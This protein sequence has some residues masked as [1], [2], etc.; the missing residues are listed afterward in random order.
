MKDSI[1]KITHRIQDRWLKKHQK[2]EDPDRL[3]LS[4]RELDLPRQIESY[5]EQCELQGIL[6]HVGSHAHLAARL[7][8]LSNHPHRTRVIGQDRVKFCPNGE[9]E[10][11]Y[12]RE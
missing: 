2:P 9:R 6:E 5:A 3:S 10:S 11:G 7:L 4:T 8:I 1:K 12:C